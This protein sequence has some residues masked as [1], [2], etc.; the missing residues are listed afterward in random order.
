MR[1]MAACIVIE[2]FYG[3]SHA[4][5]VDLLTLTFD[6]EA[7]TLPAK[8]WPWR[9]RASALHFALTVPL[10]KPSWKYDLP[11][12]W[13]DVAYYPWIVMDAI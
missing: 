10:C 13:A 5:L 11:H 9:M 1:T 12:A 7:F 3:D 6:A 4:Q 2:P 8:K